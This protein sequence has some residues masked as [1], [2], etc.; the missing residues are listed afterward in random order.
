MNRGGYAE[1]WVAEGR[2]DYDQEGM[3]ERVGQ[4]GSLCAS[5]VGREMGD[6][7]L[8]PVR[9]YLEL[10]STFDELKCPTVS[11]AGSGAD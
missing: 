5:W 7:A 2:F 10:R 1:E 8:A 3:L 4:P 6:V 9:R 11:R